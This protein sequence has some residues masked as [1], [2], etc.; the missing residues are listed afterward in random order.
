MVLERYS[1]LLIQGKIKIVD[2]YGRKNLKFT[3]AVSFVCFRFI[4]NFKTVSFMCLM[5]TKNSPKPAV[6]CLV[7]ARILRATP[8]RV[9]SQ[10]PA[11]LP[12]GNVQSKC[13]KQTLEESTEKTTI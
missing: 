7:P 6:F 8:T 4:R 13:Y 10:L 2:Y 12:A 3:K 11:L 9:P 1:Y 5:S